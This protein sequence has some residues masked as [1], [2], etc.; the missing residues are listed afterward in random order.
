MSEFSALG[1]AAVSS[2]FASSGVSSVLA[3]SGLGGLEDDEQEVNEEVLPG[4]C[5]NTAC[6]QILPA[7]LFRYDRNRRKHWS[8]TSTFGRQ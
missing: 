3:N 4:E 7:C 2:A 6:Q 5:R 8:A 1:P